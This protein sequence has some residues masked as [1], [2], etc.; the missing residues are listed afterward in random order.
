MSGRLVEQLHG[1][2]D[3]VLAGRVEQLAPLRRATLVVTGGTGFLGTWLAELVARLNDRHG[4]G[5]QVVLVAR[6]TDRFKLACPHLAAR[7]D[8][9][10]LKADVRHMFEVPKETSFLV[11]AAANPDNRFH[12]TNPIETMTVIGEG[13]SSILRAADRCSDLRMF[14]NV[15]S[16]LVTGSQPMDLERIPESHP[17]APAAGSVSSAYAEA[18]RYAETLCAAAR[19]QGRI[20]LVI[21]R[22]F[23]F[24]GPY[25][26]LDSPWA[27]NNFVRDALRGD[28]IRVFGDGQTVRSYMYATDMAFWILRLAT[29]GTSGLVYNVGSPDGVTLESA[30]RLVSNHF[31]PRPEIRLRTAPTAAQRSR[32]VPD[33]SLAAKSLGLAVTV[34]LDEAIERTVRWNRELLESSK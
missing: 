33:V 23:A 9:R 24:I 7:E 10:A 15:S 14:V 29:A 16:G 30:A 1:E 17:G 21:A 26:S 2:V 32:F 28:A 13:T 3:A 19:S 11:H 27:I 8:V 12:A 20:P 4:F 25:Q 31:T 34:G 22:P 6:S 18:K 5:A